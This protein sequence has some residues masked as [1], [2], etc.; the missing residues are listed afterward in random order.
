MTIRHLKIFIAVY[1]ERNMTMA[2]NKLFITQP[3]V[4]Q[5]IKELENYYGVELFERISNKLYVTES[6]KKVYQYA[7]HIMKLFDELEDGLKENAPKK[8]LIIGANYTVGVV[9]IHKYI[10][11]F[12]SL[13]SNS[14]IKVI[15]NK[16]S[17]LKE[18]LR[19]NELDLALIE[20]IKNESDFIEDFFYNDRIVVVADPE[21][22]LF[23][24]NEVT[25]YDVVNEHLLL[26]EKGA[27]VRN[28]FELKMNQIGLVIE[29]YWEST[30]TTALINAAENKIGIAVLPFELVKD[31]IDSGCL[32]ELKVKDIDLSR[33]LIVI[34]H[35]DKFLTS[36]MKDFIE[37][38]H[39]L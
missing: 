21:H 18:M 3:S 33:K 5:A 29:P 2:A 16:A 30:S 6:G 4:S 13:Y 12:N 32:R 11:K 7:K 26:R 17:I 27:G 23:Q 19:K 10:K 39:E 22:P 24:Q 8:K 1:N 9:L 31:H 15:V 25:A 38:C 35:K 36:A 14:E 34:Y 20:E 28:L 37:I